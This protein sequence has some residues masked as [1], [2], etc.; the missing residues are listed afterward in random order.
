MP[1]INLHRNLQ[2]MKMPD[3][4]GRS[5]ALNGQLPLDRAA[6]TTKQPVV[7]ALVRAALVRQRESKQQSEEL[8]H[9]RLTRGR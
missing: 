8:K 5:R 3:R 1:R 2:H 6:Y 4:S 7:G 9:T